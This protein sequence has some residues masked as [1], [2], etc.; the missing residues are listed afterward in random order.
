MALTSPFILPYAEILPEIGS[1]PAHAGAGSA[2]L[3]R[4]TLGNNPWLGELSVVR[5]DGH[6][7]RAGDDLHLG[8]RS[9]LHIAHD[10][11]PC[12]VGHRVAIGRNCCVHACTVGNGVTISDG[13][14]ILDGSV[15]ED[16]V[17]FEASSAVFPGKKIESGFLYGGSPA[18]RIRALEP[19]EAVAWR[20]RV[21]QGNVEKE[22][23]A[24]DHVELGRHRLP[25]GA[26]IDSSVFVAATASLN[27]HIVAGENS[28]IWFS[29]EFDAAAGAITIGQRSN[30][31]DNTI[32]RCSTTQGVVI[33]NETTIGHNVT[34]HDCVIGGRSLIGI[35]SL[36]AAGTVIDDNVLLAANSKTSAGQVLESGWLWGGNPARPIS[37][38]DQNKMNMIAAISVH[39]VH[40]A[41][42]YKA[43]QKRLDM[44]NTY[45]PGKAAN[46]PVS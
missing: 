3:G 24:L 30:I 36:I 39:Y 32:I 11:F 4:A 26:E 43:S 41:T 45:P 21:I 16:N 40:Y 1:P 5:A 6:F 19:D 9:T 13:C 28:S 37:R 18:K 20:E 8:Q 27:G 15:I 34:I 7:V 44:A 2:V 10:I 33:G 29:N 23:S 17:V 25:L 35:G 42:Q 22:S 12:I 31:Q 38:L 46:G 14:I